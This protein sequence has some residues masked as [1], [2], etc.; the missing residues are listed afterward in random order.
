MHVTFDPDLRYDRVIGI[1]ATRRE[2]NLSDRMSSV[3]V[4]RVQP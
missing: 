3:R 4:G 1:A 2:G